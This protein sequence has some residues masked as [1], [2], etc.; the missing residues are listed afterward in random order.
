LERRGRKRTGAVVVAGTGKAKQAG[1]VKG[2]AVKKAGAGMAEREK[3][4]V[5]SAVVKK[6]RAK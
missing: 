5:K 6:N 4:G 2:P 1:G 3:A